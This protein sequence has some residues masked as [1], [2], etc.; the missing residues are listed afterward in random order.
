MKQ[1]VRAEE[2]K[3]TFYCTFLLLLVIEKSDHVF[4]ILDWN[5]VEAKIKYRKFNIVYKYTYI[6]LCVQVC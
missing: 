2:N 1:S 5:N 3:D 4:N 6:C